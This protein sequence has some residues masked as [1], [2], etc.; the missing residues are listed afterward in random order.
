MMTKTSEQCEIVVLRKLK[1]E[2]ERALDLLSLRFGVH[3]DT[4]YEAVRIA[5]CE[6]Q[7]MESGSNVVQLKR[8]KP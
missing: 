1:R 3:G 2:Y 7:E 5:R 6:T 4:V 8:D